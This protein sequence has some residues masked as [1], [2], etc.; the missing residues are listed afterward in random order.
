MCVFKVV[1]L[2]GIVMS[3]DDIFGC[4]R[5]MHGHN[6]SR[7]TVRVLAVLAASAKKC[8]HVHYQTYAVAL[9]PQP[10]LLVCTRPAN[11]SAA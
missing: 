8:S 5:R 10:Q 11:I 6:V 3:L 4:W 9:D 7:S 1:V 2:E